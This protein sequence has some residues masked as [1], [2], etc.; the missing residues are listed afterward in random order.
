[1]TDFGPVNADPA[2][3]LSNLW[4]PYQLRH[5]TSA[6]GMDLMKSQVSTMVSPGRAWPAW[7]SQAKSWATPASCR[8]AGDRL[9]GPRHQQIERQAQVMRRRSANGAR[10]LDN[11]EFRFRLRAR[12]PLGR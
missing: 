10:Q 6:L 12:K 5:L 9:L 2:P 1:M 8:R 7:I 11:G 4:Q 3:D